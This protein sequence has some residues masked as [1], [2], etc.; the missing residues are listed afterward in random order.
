MDLA[1]F[2]RDLPTLE[3]PRLVLRKLRR[4]DAAGY[5]AFGSDPRVTQY[6]RWDPHASLEV[7][8]SY[9]EEVLLGYEAGRDGPWGIEIAETGDLAGSTHVMQIQPEDG[10][11][12][13]G[14]LLACRYWRQG[15]HRV[16]AFVIS[17]NIAGR[18]L[19]ETCGMAWE[20][21]LRDYCVQKGAYQTFDLYAILAGD[22]R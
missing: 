16:Q 10:R 20:G 4:E 11:A 3:T 15:L 18:K 1:S 19:M 17:E 7:T 2:Y 21:R 6:L 9:L 14:I 12:D 22:Q 8:A 5:F 13:V